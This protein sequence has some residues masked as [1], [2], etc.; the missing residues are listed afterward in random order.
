MQTK[1]PILEHKETSTNGSRAALINHNYTVAV[2]TMPNP[3]LG[4]V[5]EPR[6]LGNMRAIFVINAEYARR[7]LQLHPDRR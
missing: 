1:E 7:S 2:F 3:R 5:M 4:E 6:M